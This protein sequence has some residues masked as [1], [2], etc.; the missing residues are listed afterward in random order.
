MKNEERRPQGGS[1]EPPAVA[2]APGKPV[3]WD[4]PKI[5]A[6]VLSITSLAVSLFV[7]YFQNIQVRHELRG[8]LYYVG[9]GDANTRDVLR[10]EFLIANSGNQVE[11]VRSV[12][13]V[14]AATPDCY[15]GF[16]WA[17]DLAPSPTTLK[18]G[19]SLVLKLS[20]PMTAERRNTAKRLNF[21]P[22]GTFERQAFIC[23]LFNV[24]APN[25]EP[26]NAMYRFGAVQIDDD[27]TLD[28][29][30]DHLTVNRGLIKLPDE[31]PAPKAKPI[32]VFVP[33]ISASRP[34]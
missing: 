21:Q 30:Y 12:E 11:V 29:P 18:A 27:G 32:S 34:Y 23:G 5:V 6:V 20:I 4:S 3:A 19:E 8:A 22:G 31:H 14:L 17:A 15:G 10:G 9:L 1:A 16:I 28:G 25:G 24:V 13:F 2:S 26:D 33:T 7:F